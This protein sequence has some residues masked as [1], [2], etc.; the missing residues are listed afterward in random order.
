MGSTESLPTDF[1]RTIRF[2]NAPP[3]TACRPPRTAH[4]PI[5]LNS[6]LKARPHKAQGYNSGVNMSAQCGL[7]VRAR[8]SMR[9]EA[10]E[11]LDCPFG[12]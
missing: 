12:P 1:Q 7:K 10:Q 11:E 3:R 4:P 5:N 8:H 6:G 9:E 2:L